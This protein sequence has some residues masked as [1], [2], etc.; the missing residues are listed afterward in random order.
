MSIHAPS[1]SIRI[2]QRDDGV[3]I[4]YATSG[5]GPPLVLAP[6]WF[7]HLQLN[8]ESAVWR[9]WNQSLS[10]YYTLVRYDPCGCGVSDREVPDLSFGAWVRDLKA[11]TDALELDN[12]PILGF[13]QG[14]A[15]AVAYSALYPARV[16]RLILYGSY[17]QGIYTT[18]DT[19]GIKLAQ[20]MEEMIRQGWGV[21][22][23]AYQELFANLLIPEGSSEYLAALCD[24]Q[25]R[26]ASA[27]VA[28]QL[29]NV[30]Q[31][32]N[33]CEQAR[34]IDQPVLV[35]HQR[36][37]SMI[38]FEQGQRMAGLLPNAQFLPL[39]GTNHMMTPDEPSWDSFMTAIHAFLADEKAST[40]N[41]LEALTTRE[42]AVLDRIARGL[43]NGE[44][45][46]NLCISEKT[47]RNHITHI[48]AKLDIR[49]RSQAIVR[50]R[51]AGL[52]R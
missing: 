44:I 36:R 8:W 3:N 20:G 25:R 50:A 35:V 6:G 14:A 47:V 48:F 1:Q 4:A 31:S 42:H 51:D 18:S 34:S 27:E 40:G 21:D 19:D 37:D 45:A 11:V 32:F 49:N 22:A 39:E 5:A 12:F 23:P 7:T 17:P 10:R 52:G 29:F 30:F 38:P 26:S 9:H 33:V 46:D 24:L 43:S 41:R 2:C 28:A 13:C 16:S 15:V